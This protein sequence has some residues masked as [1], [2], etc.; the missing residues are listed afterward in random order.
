MTGMSLLR[1]VY[2][3][4]EQPELLADEA[5]CENGLLAVNQIYSELWHREHREDFVPLDNLGQR[6]ALSGRCLPAMTY[7]TAMLLCLGNEEGAH[8]DRYL[9]LYRR[10]ASLTG[11]MPMQRGYAMPT[12]EVSA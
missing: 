11:G 9:E 7:G 8:Y 3:L 6:L 2:S 5:G 10:A 4:L 12:E 1:Q